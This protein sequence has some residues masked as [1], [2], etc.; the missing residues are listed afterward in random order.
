MN[1]VKRPVEL[2]GFLEDLNR[3]YD[4]I[5]DHFDFRPFREKGLWGKMVYPGI[6]VIENDNGFTVS[7]ELPGLERKD[8][9]VSIAGKVLSIKG[10]KKEEKTIMDSGMIRKASWYNAFYR[11][12][13]LPPGIDVIKSWAELK[14]GVLMIVLPRKKAADVRRFSLQRS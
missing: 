1:V 9:N 14:N 6:D 12:L 13:P 7:C 11:S 5:L 4:E 10:G 2:A 3:L 8:L